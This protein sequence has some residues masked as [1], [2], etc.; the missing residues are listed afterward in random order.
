VSRITEGLLEPG[1]ALPSERQLCDDFGLSRTT[2][3]EALRQLAQ[4]GMISTVAGRG[5]FVSS[6]QPELAVRVSLRGFPADLCRQGMEPS[7]KLLGTKLV[8]S[9]SPSLVDR[10]ALD[11]DDEVVVLE[12]LRLVDDT[13][14]ALHTHHVNHR[15]CPDLLRRNLSHVSVFELLSTAYDLTPA[16][17]EEEAYA[18]LANERETEL[19]ELSHPCAVL[20]TE[21]TTFLDS[22]DVI[23]FTETSYRGEW[24]RLKVAVERVG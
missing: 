10:M 4:L 15:F 2:V 24:Y 7:N 11:P 12:Q 17:A 5:A 23:G 21:R 20:R 1:D 6:S 3:R 8:K 14:L 18:T 13:P 16:Y 9:P 19:L 22:G